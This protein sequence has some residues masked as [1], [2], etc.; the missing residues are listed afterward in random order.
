MLQKSGVA[1][2]KQAKAREAEDSN[3]LTQRR[4]IS[5][6][7]CGLKKPKEED[8]AALE[9]QRSQKAQAELSEKERL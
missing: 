4:G 2:Q 5:P 9:Q 1:R 3:G 6:R 7:R 8:A